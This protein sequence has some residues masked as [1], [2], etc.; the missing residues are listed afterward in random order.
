M[1]APDMKNMPDLK[2]VSLEEF[3]PERDLKPVAD[4]VDQYLAGEGGELPSEA[5][6]GTQEGADV[7]SLIREVTYEMDDRERKE[8]LAANKQAVEDNMPAFVSYLKEMGPPSQ[9]SGAVGASIGPEMKKALTRAWGYLDGAEKKE[10]LA[11]FKA[12]FES[13]GDEFE[14]VKQ[15]MLSE[16]MPGDEQGMGKQGMPGKGNM[17]APMK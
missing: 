6:A 1:P 15:S 16:K 4:F 12:G 9:W 7:S 17:P 5:D 8:I 2:P 13:R 3:D 10:V 14:N 11:A